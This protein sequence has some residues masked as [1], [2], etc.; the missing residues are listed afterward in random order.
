M[1][2]DRPPQEQLIPNIWGIWEEMYHSADY[3]ENL[4]NDVGQDISNFAK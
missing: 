4:K 2:K 3:W 1:E